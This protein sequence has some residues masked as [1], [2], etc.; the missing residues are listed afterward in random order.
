MYHQQCPYFM[1]NIYQTYGMP[2]MRNEQVPQMMS[3]ESTM[4]E[5]QLGAMYSKT[6]FIIYPHVIHHCD[7]FD[8]ACCSMKI[9]TSDEIKKMIDEIS[10]KVEPEVEASMKSGTRE[11][12]NDETESRQFGFGAR[13]LLRDFI[14]VLLLR[15]FF[16]RRQ[17]PH[18]RFMHHHHMGY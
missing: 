16:D 11:Y 12:E 1:Q 6:Y 9:P 4:P 13:G 5:D 15:E 7:I 14:G 8:K 3:P 18:H 10:M 2:Y 17:R